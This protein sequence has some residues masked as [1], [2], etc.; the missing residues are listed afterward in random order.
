[1]AIPDAEHATIC[2]FP[3]CDRPATAARHR[4]SALI[5]DTQILAREPSGP[6]RPR[7]STG[8]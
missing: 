2:R 3:G 1:M 4:L 6:S 5:L 7:W 8:R